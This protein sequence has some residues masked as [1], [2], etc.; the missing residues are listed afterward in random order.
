MQGSFC[1]NGST[2]LGGILLMIGALFVYI[3]LNGGH[4]RG[5]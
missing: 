3:A 1:L 4:I 5:A 2:V